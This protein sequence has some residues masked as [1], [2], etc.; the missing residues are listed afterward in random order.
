MNRC[1]SPDVHGH[2]TS[3]ANSQVSPDRTGNHRPFSDYGGALEARIAL[4]LRQETTAAD[5]DFH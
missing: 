5:N 1:H 2:S 4:R 3:I